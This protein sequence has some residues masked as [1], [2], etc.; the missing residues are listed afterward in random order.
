[1]YMYI[2]H[3]STYMYMYI[4]SDIHVHVQ[5]NLLWTPLKYGHHS[6]MGTCFCPIVVILYKT[7]PELR[8][9][10]V[11]VHDSQWCPQ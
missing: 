7:T 2:V 10:T 11:T 5:W 6:N 1:M 3:V 8:I 4:H 9:R